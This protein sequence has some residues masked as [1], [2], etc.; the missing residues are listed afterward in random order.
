MPNNPSPCRRCILLALACFA[1]LGTYA[2][3]QETEQDPFAPEKPYDPQEA[4]KRRQELTAMTRALQKL[5]KDRPNIRTTHPDDF[6]RAQLKLE[7]CALLFQRYYPSAA[8]DA[9]FKTELD[10]GRRVVAALAQGKSAPL[11]RTGMIERAYLSDVDRSAQP[12]YVFIPDTVDLAKPAPLLLF[13]HGYI[14]N[15]DKVNWV[16]QTLSESM[17]IL[18]EKL[19]GILLVPFARSN[20]DFLGLGERDV[21][22]TIN[23][24]KRDYRIDA[25]RVYLCG[26]SMGGSGVW[27]IA[28]HYP[29]L[30]AAAVP[31]SGRN[32]YNLWQNVERGTLTEFK[33]FIIDRDY[34]VVLKPNF[35]NLP[36]FAFHGENDTLVKPDQ[37]RKMVAAL[38][39]LAFE[40]RY[41][42]FPRGDHWSCFDAF[43]SD[44]LIAWLGTRK[45]DAN[46]RRV[47]YTTYHPRLNEAHWVRIDDFSAFGTPATIDATRTAPDLV[48]AQITNISRLT[49]GDGRHFVAT[50]KLRLR[51]SDG[52][53]LKPTGVTGG[54][55]RFLVNPVAVDAGGLRKRGE[56]CG[57]VYEAYQH[58]FLFVF[59]TQGDAEG[60]LQSRS[61]ASL[62]MLEWYEFAA[63]VPRV[64]K[65]TDVSADDIKRFNLILFGTPKSNLILGRI[66]PKLPITIGKDRF[67][68]GGKTYTGKDLGLVMIY[69]NPLSPART[70]VVHSGVR[71]GKG[72]PR[73]HKLD[74]LPDYIVFDDTIAAVSGTNTFK[75]AGFFDINWKLSA[76]LMWTGPEKAPPAPEFPG[77][78]DPWQD[79]PLEDDP[80]EAPKTP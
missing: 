12:Y 72:L 10:E 56:V 70:V 60:Q 27:A 59:G 55:A 26:A 62:A 58:P 39:A 61:L 9:S 40:A 19:N 28:A 16:D 31:A 4:L 34:A 1:V 73:N 41:E 36:V 69:P 25:D 67:V 45:R 24:V 44:K 51:L 13:L 78:D 22:K 54:R 23:L 7:K 8:R 18:T 5:L 57:P 43:D 53:T 17:K 38:K 46:P 15:L 11:P 68:V 49:I 79:D 63:G 3:A 35:R 21:L 37:S 47:T 52:R 76:T 75:V 14:G 74:L 42:E 2:A 50:D 77:W 20:T 32:D 71:W 66:A 64:K 48:T 33:Q 30:F 80:P 65:D 29:H 6:A